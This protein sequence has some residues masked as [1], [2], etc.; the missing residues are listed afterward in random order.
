MEAMITMLFS[1]QAST[2]SMAK[3]LAW[4]PPRDMLTGMVWV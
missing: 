3:A 4:D 1:V 2:A